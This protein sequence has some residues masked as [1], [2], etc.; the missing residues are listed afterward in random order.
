MSRRPVVLLVTAFLLTAALFFYLTADDGSNEL[1]FS[2]WGTPAE[3]GSFQKLI[4]CYNTTRQPKHKV[5]LAHSEHTS[6]T[7][8]LLIYRISSTSIGK[9]CPCSSTKDCWKNSRPL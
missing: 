6:Y 2:T 1:V 5:K 7:E 3:V 8:L 9:T 4:D